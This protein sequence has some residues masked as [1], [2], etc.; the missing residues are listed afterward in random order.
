MFF[1]CLFANGTRKTRKSKHSQNI[2]GTIIGI[3]IPFSVALSIIVN[4][5]APLSCSFR[6]A[7]YFFMEMHGL[8]K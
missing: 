7:I 5:L 6:T 1:V 3:V 8:K 2:V 4:N